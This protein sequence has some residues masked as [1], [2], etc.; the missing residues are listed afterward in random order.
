VK[1]T[2]TGPDTWPEWW[3]R[4]LRRLGRPSLGLLALGVLMPT[5]AVAQ[6]VQPF[7]AV[8]AASMLMVLPG[9][10]VGRLMR[11]DDPYLLLLVAVSSSLALTVLTSTLLMYA[12]VWSWQLTLVLLGLVTAATSAVTSMNGGPR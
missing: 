4:R 3:S 10:A 5:V 7:R 1:L 12:G 11:L 6:P 8:A 9:L 2:Q